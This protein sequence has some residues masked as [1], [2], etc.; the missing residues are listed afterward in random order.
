MKRL[1]LNHQSYRTP[2]RN[3]S[4][5]SNNYLFNGFLLNWGHLTQS[6]KVV[7]LGICLIPIWWFWGWSYLL[8]FLGSGIFIHDIWKYK[9]VR[10]KKPSV[11]VIAFVLYGLLDLINTIFYGLYNSSSISLRDLIGAS[12]TVFAPAFILWYIQSKNIRVRPLVIIWSFSL[13]VLLMVGAWAYIFFVHHQASF[14]PPRSLFGLLTGKPEQ[15]APGLGNTNYLI[16]YRPED[17][18]IAGFSRYFYFF[19]GP[20]SLA[21]VCAFICLL[22][23]D[24]NSQLWK[25][26]LFS[27]AGFILLT[28]GTRSVWLSLPFVLFIWLLWTA[29]Q[30][31]GSWFACAFIATFS[32][33][34]L[35][36][37]TATNFVMDEVADTA[38]STSEF[39]GDSTD[40]RAEI[41]RQTY[42]RLLNSSNAKLFLG[43]VVPGETVLPGYAPAMI[44][45]HSFYLGSLLYIRG[46]VGTII[47]LVFWVT[48]IRWLIQT[49]KERPLG[50]ILI[51]LL[52]SLTFFVMAFESVVMPIAL[53]ASVT[54]RFGSQSIKVQ[55]TKA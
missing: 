50:S 23:L 47:F 52:F 51:F 55:M 46:L 48:L 38:K 30:S 25:V 15:Y 32:A 20:E 35:M 44:G 6:E 36:F 11:M 33:V 42:E 45:T 41:Y 22:S 16:P 17:S 54:Q 9:G 2:N 18:S 53:I 31:K 37:P 40:V 8:L 34:L 27:G 12:N 3:Y 10:L 5:S 1:S 26:S 49:R 21:L 24:L 7:C 29:G 39:R 13:L 19:H 28:S 4:L 43:H 14:T